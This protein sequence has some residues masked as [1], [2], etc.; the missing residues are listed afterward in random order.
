VVASFDKIFMPPWHSL[1]FIS[2][3]EPDGALLEAKRIVLTGTSVS[4]FFESAL[5]SKAPCFDKYKCF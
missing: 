5:G 3:P 2:N 4:G 1:I